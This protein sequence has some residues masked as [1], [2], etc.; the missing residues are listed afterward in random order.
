MLIKTIA[1]VIALH[2]DLHVINRYNRVAICD[3]L[4][5]K[6][7]VFLFERA[8]DRDT[9]MLNACLGMSGWFLVEQLSNKVHLNGGRHQ[10]DDQLRDRPYL[11]VRIIVQQQ[12]EISRFPAPT[13]MLSL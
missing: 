3:C 6:N 7:S 8:I 10:N 4:I 5:T 1:R 9:S 12:I 13:P 11:Y 2:T